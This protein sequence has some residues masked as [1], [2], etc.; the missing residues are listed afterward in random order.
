MNETR[1]T[2]LAGAAIAGG[3]V[4]L[5]QT[6][7]PASA[8]QSASEGAS[9]PVDVPAPDLYASKLTPDNCVAVLV[10]YLDGFLPGLRTASPEAYEASV[11][12]FVRTVKLFDLPTIVLGDEG[13]FRGEFFP[14]VKELFPPDEYTYAGRTTPSAWRS[15]AMRE[16]IEEQGRPR[17]VIGGISIDNCTALTSLDLLANG[18]LPH[19]VV[20]ASGT[21]S[22][23]VERAAMMRLSQA[24]AV[25]TNWVQLGSELLESWETPEGPE[26]GSLYSEYSRWGALGVPEAAEGSA[27]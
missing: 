23:V 7:T 20:D 18:Y 1:R 26:L 5:A 9:G 4:A 24:G 25:M 13:G 19:V 17:V 16:W 22:D 21:E 12:G 8:Q 3:T 6:T 10:D 11:Q 2:F 27:G 15:G 14:F